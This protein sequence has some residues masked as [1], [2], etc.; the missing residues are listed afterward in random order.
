MQ[1]ADP[2]MLTA[3]V[4]WSLDATTNRRSAAPTMGI[5]AFGKKAYQ[6]NIPIK[7]SLVRALTT[8]G[9]MVKLSK[10]EAEYGKKIS[11]SPIH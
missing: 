5:G 2:V 6:D 8:L 1:A 9:G 3:E 7:R 11:G 10:T 4:T